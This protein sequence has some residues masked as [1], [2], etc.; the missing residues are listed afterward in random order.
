MFDQN[1]L[2]MAFLMLCFAGLATMFYFLMRNIDELTRMLKEDR[3]QM[4][5]NLRALESSLNH[6]GDLLSRLTADPSAPRGAAPLR[7]D[8]L[9]PDPLRSDP[10]RPDPLRPAPVP[11]MAA[12]IQ[13]ADVGLG[14]RPQARP[15]VSAVREPQSLR[16]PASD[17]NPAAPGVSMVNLSASGL[18]GPGAAQGVPAPGYA[19]LPFSEPGGFR[20]NVD[21]RGGGPVSPSAPA[22]PGVSAPQAK[23]PASSGPGAS[24]LPDL[25]LDNVG[26]AR[27]R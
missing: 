17:E 26:Q 13:M 14:A 10:L 1:F 18:S 27:R 16:M 15:A 20:L 22:A 23:G 2:F 8:P 19:P 7:S 6:L 3:N 25:S 21:P 12:P 11:G 9:R 24:T 5:T 4:Q